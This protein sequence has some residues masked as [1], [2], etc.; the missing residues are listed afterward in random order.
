[1]ITLKHYQERV[2]DSLRVCDAD[3]RR[4]FHHRTRGKTALT[5][6]RLAVIGAPITL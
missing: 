5:P 1:M 4:F 2:L 3:G 6:M